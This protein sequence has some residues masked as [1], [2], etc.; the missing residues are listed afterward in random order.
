MFHDFCSIPP[1]A[2]SSKNRETP[3]REEWGVIR[4]SEA[5]VVTG[6]P[7]LQRYA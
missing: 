6:V 2:G 3:F 1:E 5:S 4:E 7:R